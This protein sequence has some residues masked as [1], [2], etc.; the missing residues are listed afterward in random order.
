MMS[1]H[2]RATAA[3][4]DMDIIFSFPSTY[5]GKLDTVQSF[6]QNP[7]LL[8]PFDFINYQSHRIN[9]QVTPEPSDQN[10]STTRE[11]NFEK[12]IESGT[13]QELVNTQVQYPAFPFYDEEDILNLDADVDTPPPRMSRTIPVKLIYEEPSEPMPVEDPWQ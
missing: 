11:L 9:K 1:E 13:T 6:G 4:T 12:E 5:V 3:T 10:T 2:Y 7:S 8:F